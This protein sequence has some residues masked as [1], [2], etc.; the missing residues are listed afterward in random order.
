MFRLRKSQISP[1]ISERVDRVETLINSIIQHQNLSSH[2]GKH[3]ADVQSK[4]Q[5]LPQVLGTQ[6]D[7]LAKQTSQ[8]NNMCLQEQQVAKQY[9][10]SEQGVN[11]LSIKEG[12]IPL[13][14]INSLCFTCLNYTFHL[15]YARGY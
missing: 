2:Q 6:N 13:N 15:L 10:N 4:Q 8:R 14:S 1:E 3:S 11:Q 12:K 9:G 5:V 7:H